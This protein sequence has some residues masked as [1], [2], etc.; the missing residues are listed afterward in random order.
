MDNIEDSILSYYIK[1]NDSLQEKIKFLEEQINS[2]KKQIEE[3]K[4]Q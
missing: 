4:T 2:L 3:I 1:Q